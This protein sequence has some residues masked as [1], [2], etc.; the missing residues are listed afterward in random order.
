MLGVIP[1]KYNKD[2]VTYNIPIAIWIKYKYPAIPPDFY[3][4]PAENMRIVDGH[5]VAVNGKI[6]HHYLNT[7]ITNPEVHIFFYYY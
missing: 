2:N 6:S 5:H 7:Y 4:T 3:V 1:V